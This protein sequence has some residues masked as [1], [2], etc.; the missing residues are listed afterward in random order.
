MTHRKNCA[1][2]IWAALL[3]L[4]NSGLVFAQ[5]QSADNHGRAFGIGQPNSIQD[6]P[7]GQ[8][9][10]DLEALPA[11]AR[12]KALGWLREFSFPAEDVSSLRTNA[13]G[14]I[15]YAEPVVSNTANPST[16]EP[17][18]NAAAM[19]AS[20]VF[21]LH[22]RPG[23]NNVVFLDFD[24]HTIEATSGWTWTPLEALP[25]DPSQNDNP[26]TVANFT[27]DEL[28]RIAEIWHRISEDYASFNIDVTTEEPLEFTPTTARLL[29]THDTD[30]NG[31]AMPHQGVGG[32]AFINMFGRD[33]FVSTYSP[34]FVYY[35]NL[36]T[37]NFGATTLNAE[38]G[39]HELGHNLGLSHDGTSGLDYYEGHGNGLVS[40][41]PIMGRPFS[42][43]VTHWSQGEYPDANNS[44]DDLAI[45]A[46]KLGWIS[47]DHGD[48]A[49][50][51]SPLQVE[52]NGDILVSSPEFDPENV[53]PENKGTINDRT[54][55]D[56][57]YID[58]TDSGSLSITATPAWHS[59]ARSDNRG[60]NLDIE[61]SLFDN[62]LQLLAVGEPDDDTMAT[63]A[64]TATTGR[65]YLQVHGAGNN[66]NSDYGDYASMGM[67]F[68]E[69][70][71]PV[72]P[73]D[74]TPPS[75]ASMS[76]QSAPNATGE[77]TISMTAIQATDDSGAVE[78]LF[79]CVAG[80]TGC[81]DSGW[82]AS[83]SHTAS[84]L[85]PNTHYAYTV[86]A[87]D[88]M[89]NQNNASSSTGDTT[90]AAPVNSAPVA[91][92]FY[93]PKPAIITKG[94]TVSVTL[95][96][97]SSSDSD[98][99]IASW[100]WKDS[101][102]SL[103]GNSSAVTVKL[104]QGTHVFNLT[105]TDNNGATDSTSLSISVTKPSDGGGGGKPCNP[106][107]RTCG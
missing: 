80:G 56:W 15:Y 10:R 77:S 82:Q 35:T 45:I 12:G 4:I 50:Q 63:V 75:P 62:N 51:A 91:S 61:L 32:V 98:G 37:N 24:G 16:T 38:A 29:F 42:A 66:T 105:V 58:I 67:Y 100:S 34:T 21:K 7:P 49:A 22:S 76:W 27:Q 88:A 43:N 18:P 93:S 72:G 94:K 28:N 71:I 19:N 23:S 78:Y 36:S 86:K 53:L 44:Q 84:G 33:N 20:Q 25:F 47:D 40:W 14:A 9:R 97:S 79:S 64:L 6:L 107:K 11:K 96:G 73:I 17:A 70:N 106:K 41:A 74:E 90:D 101:S 31:D 59:F 8:L 2:L 68:L 65:Y 26:A 30:A 69:G 95:N 104:A 87:R 83:R 46:G 52:P 102:G 85:S 103:V 57:F 13:D 99:T 1:P 55:V 5:G 92:A 54:D 3:L 89:G 39:S 60:A 48:S 81:T